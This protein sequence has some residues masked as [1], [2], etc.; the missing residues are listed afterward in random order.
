MRKIICIIFFNII[1]CNQ[2]ISVEK[3]NLKYLPE[4]FDKLQVCTEYY[5]FIKENEPSQKSEAKM[6]VYFTELNK[7]KDFNFTIKLL[8]DNAKKLNK[9]FTTL[10]GEG[11]TK[12]NLNKRYKKTCDRLIFRKGI[13]LPWDAFEAVANEKELFLQARLIIDLFADFTIAYKFER[14]DKSDLS[15][16]NLEGVNIDTSKLDEIVKLDEKVLEFENVE[17]SNESAKV[18]KN[19]SKNLRG[20][21]LW[22][23]WRGDENLGFGFEFN[24]NNKVKLKGIDDD[25][26]KLITIKGEYQALSNKII[27][28]YKNLDNSDEEITISRKT[29]KIIGS[30]NSSCKPINKSSYIDNKLKFA[31]DKLIGEKSSENKF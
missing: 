2:A 4:V 19:K 14:K 13:A 24:K 28:K 25:N 7:Y 9:Y 15:L 5:K 30:S 11:S 18:T 16:S 17:S 3:R 20:K 21:K 12:I 29:L 27:I 26:E 22:C 1:L 8:Q 31:L 23:S 10:P 6:G